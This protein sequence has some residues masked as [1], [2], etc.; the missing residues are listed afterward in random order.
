MNRAVIILVAAVATGFYRGGALAQN[1]PAQ[2][3][4]AQDTP[5]QSAPPQDQQPQSAPQTTPGD[6]V[7]A[8]IGAWELS[9]ADHDK[10]CRLSFRADAVSGG[11]KLDVDKNCPNVFPTTKDMAVWTVDVY[12]NLRLLDAQ[13]NAVLELTQVESGMFDGF[14]PE[15]GRFILQAAAAVQFRTASDMVGDWAIARGTGKPICTL[16]L[17]DTAVPPGGDNL[18]L[19]IKPGCDALITRFGPT[20]WHMDRGELVLLAPRGQTWRFEE[21]DPNTW[22]R[23]PETPDPVL[24]VRQ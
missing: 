1:T 23:L 7:A 20:S 17:A 8:M 21:N 22:Q 12:G 13:G 6:A 9:N 10:V 15:Q 5:A 2:N 4:P 3:T 16:T 19:K 14:T 18:A 24:L 11:Y